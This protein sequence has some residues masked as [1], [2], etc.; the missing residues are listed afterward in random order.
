MGQPSRSFFL[1]ALSFSMNERGRAS[2]GRG[3]ERERERERETERALLLNYELLAFQFLQSARLKGRERAR[4]Y[5]LG[6]LF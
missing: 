6:K 5:V 4:K 1:P 2:G 3:G